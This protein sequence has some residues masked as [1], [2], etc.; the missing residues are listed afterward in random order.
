VSVR[1]G[2]VVPLLLAVIG[3]ISPWRLC[4]PVDII[5]D[6]TVESK[7]RGSLPNNSPIDVDCR[8]GDVRTEFHGLSNF[9]G[10]CAKE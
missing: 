1:D 4:E 3:S 2:D 7:G 5:E 10:V 9:E 8:G 6:A